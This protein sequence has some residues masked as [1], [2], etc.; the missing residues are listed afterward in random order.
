MGL[1]HALAQG[2]LVFSLLADTSTEDIDYVIA[3]FGPI[4]DRLRAMSP[5]YTAFLKESLP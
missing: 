1:D 4:I 3:S 5:T 2:S